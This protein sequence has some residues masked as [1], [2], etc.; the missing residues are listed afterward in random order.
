MHKHLIPNHLFKPYKLDHWLHRCVK[1]W[2]L[3]IINLDFSVF[4]QTGV[5]KVRLLGC[6]HHRTPRHPSQLLTVGASL[7]WLH[8]SDIYSPMICHSKMTD[9]SPYSKA[10]TG[11][12]CEY[13]AFI[14]TLIQRTWTRT[15]ETRRLL[16]NG[17]LNTY[18][19]LIVTVTSGRK[20]GDQSM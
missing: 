5:P 9:I 16:S 6:V 15:A 20:V 19:S 10:T 17:S 7:L 1:C 2:F 12:K 14:F 3:S 4:M 18:S 13:G 11:H 8:Q